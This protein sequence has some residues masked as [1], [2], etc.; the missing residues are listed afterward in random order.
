MAGAVRRKMVGV[1]EPLRVLG[2]DFFRRFRLQ[3]VRIHSSVMEPT[4]TSINQVYITHDCP[5]VYHIP[6]LSGVI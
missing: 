3:E 1:G 5:S 6:H 4:N 2:T